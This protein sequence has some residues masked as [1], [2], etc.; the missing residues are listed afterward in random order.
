MADYRAIIPEQSRATELRT[1]RDAMDHVL[2]SFD[3]EFTVRDQQRARMAVLEAYRD[4]VTKHR[5]SC[6][7]R[8]GRIQTVAS[9]D[10]GTIT[11]DH[12]G[13]AYDRLLTITGTTFPAAARY[14]RVIIDDVHY[15]IE[16]YKSSTTVTLRE[17]SN[18]GADV[19]A[20]TAC[21]LYRSAYPVPMDF[22]RGGQLLQPANSTWLPRYVPFDEIVN[23]KI[24][25]DTPRDQPEWYTLRGAGETYGGG[26]AFEFYP[27][28]SS[29]RRYDFAYERTPRPLHTF[30]A[31]A[32]YATGTVTVSATTVT[33][34]GAFTQA[35]L[36]CV[37]RFTD[38]TI[39]PPTGQL[40]SGKL[41]NPYI[42]QRIVKSV[43]DATHLTI[44]EALSGT[45]SAMKY[46]IGAPVDL[47]YDV[48]LTAFHRLCERNFAV[49]LKEKRV[50]EEKEALFED[51]LHYAMGADYR[52]N[53]PVESLYGAVPLYPYAQ[54]VT[55]A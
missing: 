54:A 8:D 14:Y 5:W 52:F 55:N 28:P 24:I 9:D 46:S 40:G 17:D 1:F 2:L 47:E 51:A 7:C 13:G 20:G 21:T 37:I 48:M 10:D 42:E 27:P 29:V 12:T 4:I 3:C 11:Y 22:R 25:D 26:L 6:L 38:S 44:D 16:D 39:D 50:I 19:A 18:P 43:T 36:G 34:T 15:E 32:E 30:G 53:E 49:I 31:T 41:D 45:Y 35:M 33:G 23:A